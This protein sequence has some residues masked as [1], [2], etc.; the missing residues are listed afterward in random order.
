MTIQNAHDPS[1][2]RLDQKVRL[3]PDI[4][5]G[6]SLEVQPSKMEHFFPGGIGL[7]FP[8]VI[9]PWDDLAE[10]CDKNYYDYQPHQSH[11]IKNSPFNLP[12]GG[13]VYFDNIP[14]KQRSRRSSSCWKC[15]SIRGV[16]QHLFAK[17]TIHEWK[18]TSFKCES[19]AH[20]PLSRD[21]ALILTTQ[22]DS[23]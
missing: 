3:A 17:P 7:G 18:G 22:T 4:W 12:C 20:P 15:G 6:Q 10:L 19:F 1:W 2:T 14:K 9:R 13:T 23:T 21:L 8:M 16:M 11:P 5:P